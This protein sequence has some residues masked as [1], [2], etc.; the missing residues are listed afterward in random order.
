MVVGGGSL[1]IPMTRE[2][3]DALGETK[4]HEYYDGMC[5]VNPPALDHVFVAMRLE[6]LLDPLSPAGFRVIREWGWR[7]EE[8]D[9][10]PDLQMSPLEGA[11]GSYLLRPPLLAVEITSPSTRD[12]DRDAK[13]GRYG[14]GGLPWYWIVD[15]HEILVFR[16]QGGVLAPVQVITGPAETAGPVLVTLD[17]AA[18][19]AP[20]E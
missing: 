10:E 13:L 6:R 18:L 12:Q 14:R 3:W 8:G 1:R 5:V 19:W 17:L 11:S 20:P 4:H 15:R 7:S 16:G 2:E 9:F